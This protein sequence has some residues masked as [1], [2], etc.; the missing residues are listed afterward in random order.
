MRLTVYDVRAVRATRGAAVRRP[1]QMVTIGIRIRA[2]PKPDRVCASAAKKTTAVINNTVIAVSRTYS[3]SRVRLSNT[4]R[5]SS[6]RSPRLGREAIMPYI[7][8]ER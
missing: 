4:S 3:S 5:T 1:T 6:L 7:A 2:K 8:A